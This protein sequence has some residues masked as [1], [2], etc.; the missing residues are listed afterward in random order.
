MGG[1]RQDIET[2]IARLHGN[3][4]LR[5]WSLIVTF[6]GDAVNPR[7]GRVALGVLQDAMALLA[8]EQGAVRTALSRLAKDGWVVREREGR[9]SLYEL[10]PQ[11]RFA[12]DEATRRIYSP[13]PPE[14]HGDWTVAITDADHADRLLAQGF[15]PIGDPAWLKPGKASGVPPDSVLVIHG[16]G[17]AFPP[18]LLRLWKPDRLAVQY[19]A[20]ITDWQGFDPAGLAPADAMAAR[21]LLIHDWRRIV[22]RDPDLPAALLPAGWP[23]ATALGLVR[24]LYAGLADQSERWLDVAGLPPATRT[25][26]VVGRFN[27][28]RNIAD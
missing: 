20:F 13:G 1:A 12:F 6:F 27:V 10:S 17:T 14:W 8:I 9:F 2:H 11:G 28:L 23:G 18:E 25:G 24:R 4:R 26:G 5:V 21:T 16:E 3:G 22:L 15:V 7:G 19:E